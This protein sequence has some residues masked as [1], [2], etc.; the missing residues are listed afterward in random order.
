M[1][2]LAAFDKYMR[3]V[4]KEYSYEKSFGGIRYVFMRGVQNGSDKTG[5]F[6]D[7]PDIS[8][9]KRIQKLFEGEK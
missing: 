7:R 5:I 3:T 2:Y 6:S 8:E 1:L 4:D 9:L